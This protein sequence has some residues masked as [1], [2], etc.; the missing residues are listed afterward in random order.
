M[1]RND[2]AAGKSLHHHAPDALVD[3]FFLNGDPRLWNPCQCGAI[4]VESGGIDEDCKNK[5]D[6]VGTGD[7]EDVRESVGH[8]ALV[9]G[10]GRGEENEAEADKGE[11]EEGARIQKPFQ[12]GRHG[13]SRMVCE[14][15][16]DSVV[17]EDHSSPVGPPQVQGARLT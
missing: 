15:P 12:S 14:P 1:V 10:V 13:S 6:D 9:D 11:K 16:L 17:D 3:I 5:G 8:P 2:C 4:R 7:E